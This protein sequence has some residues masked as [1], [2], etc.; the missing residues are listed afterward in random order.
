M[1]NSPVLPWTRNRSTAPSSPQPP[2]WPWAL[3]TALVVAAVLLAALSVRHVVAGTRA[4]AKSV[5]APSV[6]AA[7]VAG[8]TPPGTYIRLA[9]L[10][11]SAGHLVALTSAAQPQCPPNGACPPAPALTT[12]TVADAA[13][14]QPL[15]TTPLTTS[16]TAPA[17]AAVL[18][19]AD[20]SRHLAYAVSPGAV[21]LFST[22][23]GAS[24]GGYA[25]PASVA[26]AWP[27]ESGGA[28]DPQRGV[29][30]LAGSGQLLALDAATGR[31]LASRVLAAGATVAGLTLDPAS[32]TV[33]ALLQSPGSAAPTL[34]AF[35]ETTLATT[36]QVPLPPGA[37][38]GPL[39][40]ATG[41]LYLP[42]ATTGQCAY[43]LRAARLVSTPIAVCDALAL[44]WNAAT[45]HLYTSDAA[46]LTLRDAATGRAL[47]AL[48]IR[49]AWPGDHP[50]LVDAT[51][52]L[53]YLPD[54]RGT[55]LL[56]RDG[57]ESAALTPGGALL[58]ARSALAALLPNTNQDPPFVAPATFPAAP[59]ARPEAY[60]IHFSDLGWQGPYPGDAASAVSPLPGAAGGY[61]VTFTITWSQLFR[62]THVWTCDVSPNGAVRL[63][64]ETGDA[65]P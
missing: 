5:P 29:L 40:T 41:T 26:A 59:G 63:A 6:P 64:A 42:G 8:A 37:R 14:G 39:D 48:P 21:T 43:S 27:R 34:A 56:V 50:L 9:A 35:D 46:G 58:L 3:G 33:Y 7:A 57:P 47:A 12:F 60:W 52:G 16:A 49:A 24:A 53:L 61:A 45:G 11:S 22:T 31:P 23:T 54:D 4:A 30:L 65:V 1:R 20:P 17:A 15:T 44:G 18:L 55:V 19:L 62:R 2:T 38:L 25:L 28:L 13:T 32:A 10:D 36:S 51:R